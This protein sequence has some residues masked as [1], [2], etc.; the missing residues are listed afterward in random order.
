MNFLIRTD[1]TSF[2]VTTAPDKNSNTRS[3]HELLRLKPCNILLMPF[4]TPQRLE[5]SPYC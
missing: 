5:V 3:S 2:K 1:T 4:I